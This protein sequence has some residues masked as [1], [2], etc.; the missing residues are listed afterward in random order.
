MTVGSTYAK[1]GDVDDLAAQAANVEKYLTFG[2]DYLVISTNQNSFNVQIT[3]DAINF[4]S[5]NKVLAYMN[6]QKLFIAESEVT[7]SQRIGNY[8]WMMP[9]TSGAVAL[10]YS[11]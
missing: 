11:P 8:L 10:I 4:R 2:N 1:R 7:E 9:D 5:G 3:N 6:N